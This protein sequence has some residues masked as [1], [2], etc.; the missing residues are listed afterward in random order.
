[1]ERQTNVAYMKDENVVDK[2]LCSAIFCDL[3]E[4]GE[5]YELEST[6]A[7]NHGSRS[8]GHFKAASPSISFTTT[9][10]TDSWTV[11]TSR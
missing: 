4:I 11:G 10:S 5:A 6:K 2:A 7:G 8:N 9:F 1:M 3:E